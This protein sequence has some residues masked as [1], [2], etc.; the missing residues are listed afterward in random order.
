[1]N[2]EQRI[3]SFLE[4]YDELQA[5]KNKRANIT[6]Y[7][8]NRVYADLESKISADLRAYGRQLIKDFP[9]D[10][11][12]VCIVYAAMPLWAP[13]LYESLGEDLR[14]DKLTTMLAIRHFDESAYGRVG[15][16]LRGDKETMFLLATHVAGE[17]SITQ[18]APSLLNDQSFWIEAMGD[19]DV[20]HLITPDDYGSF[21]Y[22][23]N[24]VNEKYN[25]KMDMG[26]LISASEYAKEKDRNYHSPL[27]VMNTY[28]SWADDPRLIREI[29]N[30]NEDVIQKW[31]TGML[32]QELLED[33]RQKAA[34]R[35]VEEAAQQ[36]QPQEEPFQ[37]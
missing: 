19:S 17:Q 7:H 18:F 15:A 35:L 2:K 26:V 25:L 36:V 4:V 23:V 24:R 13:R 1:M 11:E 3:Q 22:R 10:R 20:F 6:D 28:P 31:T 27:A 12:I 29:V 30:G 8:Q 37:K 16:S 34:Q 9:N 14:N 21:L 33:A 5:V 32:R